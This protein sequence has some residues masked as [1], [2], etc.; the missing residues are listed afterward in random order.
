MESG[1]I[2]TNRR[3]Q[4]FLSKGLESR[5]YS[6]FWEALAHEASLVVLVCEILNKD[7]CV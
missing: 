1:H 2:K 3:K 6:F 4:K 7:V 5:G